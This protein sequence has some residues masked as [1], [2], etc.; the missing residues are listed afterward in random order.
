MS[1]RAMLDGKA[2]RTW[3]VVSDGGH[4]R[5]LES[6]RPHSG[7]ALIFATDSP[8]RL[9]QGKLADDR[10]PRAKE[11]VGAMRH[12]IAPRLDLKTHEKRLFC[13]RLA[14]YLA[15]NIVHF[16]NLALVA[17]SGILS[18]I[19]QNLPAA[20]SRKLIMVEAKDL[21]WMPNSEILARLGSL[22][23]QLCK[24]RLPSQ[25]RRRLERSRQVKKSE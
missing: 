8:A 5:V 12:A 1:P 6:E 9:S 20:A 7:V 21:T 23:R 10:L 17:P 11:S 25:R 15:G 4:A 24:E 3:I 22:G 16:D 14:R 18:L 13:Q 19:R 2:S